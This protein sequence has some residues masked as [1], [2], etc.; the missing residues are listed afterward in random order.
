MTVTSKLPPKYVLL[1]GR[2]EQQI[3]SGQYRPGQALPTVRELMASERLGTATVTNGLALLE[4]RVCVTRQ[5]QRGY[6]VAGASGTKSKVSQI[7]FLTA[8]LSGDTD[9]YVRGMTEV[10]AG[11]TDLAVSTFSSHGDLERFRQAVEQVADLQPAGVVLIALPRGI[12]DL[13]LTP[14]AEARIPAV[15]IGEPMPGIAC[16]R[17]IQTGQDGGRRVL[18]HLLERGCDTPA[19]LEALPI[20]AGGQ[21][22]LWVLRTGFARAGIELTDERVFYYQSPHGWRP[23][24]DPYIDA[25]RRM[26]EALASGVRFG[27]LICRSDYQAVGAIRAIVAAGLRVPEDVAVISAVQ[28]AVDGVC[29]MRITAVDTRREDQ[30]RVAAELLI[31]RIGGHDGPPEVHHI[32]GEL[33][34]GETG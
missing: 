32:A 21:E 10:L 20:D 9:L 2:I 23:P 25:Q 15:I 22:L 17:V 18:Q 8:A 11:G 33:R 16:D 5:P 6:F 7:A 29:P 19:V 28:C 31:K 24:V 34:V 4:E 12:C 13:D 30:G 27:T 14:L 3:R 1:A 26:E